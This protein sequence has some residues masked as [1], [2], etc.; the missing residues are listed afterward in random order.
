MNIIEMVV[1]VF[2]VLVIVSTF[3]T[4]PILS[5]EYYK[6]TGKSAKI[7]IVKVKNMFGGQDDNNSKENVQEVQKTQLQ[8]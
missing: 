2:I 7:L 6:A 1:A 4:E 5:F 3:I 8:D